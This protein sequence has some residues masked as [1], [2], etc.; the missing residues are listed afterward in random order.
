MSD[1]CQMPPKATLCRLTPKEIELR[2]NPSIHTAAIELANIV[3]KKLKADGRRRTRGPLSFWTWRSPGLLLSYNTLL[4]TVSD[5]VSAHISESRLRGNVPLN[6]NC[7]EVLTIE[8]DVTF[9]CVAWSDHAYSVSEF[10]RGT[11]EAHIQALSDDS[12]D[13]G[14]S[15][16]SSL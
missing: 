8:R 16:A 10:N 9:L 5:R 13:L 6:F 15:N 2:D 11:W 7:V 12:A 4:P 1:R 14:G 3:L